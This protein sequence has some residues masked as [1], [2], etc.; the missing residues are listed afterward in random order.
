MQQEQR[1]GRW[2]YGE[3]GWERPPE[4]GHTSARVVRCFGSWR[5]EL[6]VQPLDSGLRSAPRTAH[7]STRARALE[8]ADRWLVEAQVQ[9]ADGPMQFAYEA[10]SG[11]IECTF[12]PAQVQA[13]RAAGWDGSA[14]LQQWLLQQV[15]AGAR[16]Q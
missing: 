4:S 7:C 6:H 5:V 14:P 13:I 15:Q 1:C 2:F 8:L 3:N 12:T 11:A 9:L 10:D 16:C